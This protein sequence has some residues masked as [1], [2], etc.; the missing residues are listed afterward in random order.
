MGTVLL[1]SGHEEYLGLVD[2]MLLVLPHLLASD[3]AAFYDL[4]MRCRQPDH[5]FSGNAAQR[6]TQWNLVD[7]AG[8]VNP[9]VRGI[10]LAAIAGDGLEMHI[11]APYN[12][13]GAAVQPQ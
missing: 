1:T 5:R 4:V 3:G 7:S 10:A 6:L 11:V 2:I 12:P 8:Q 9:G 13:D